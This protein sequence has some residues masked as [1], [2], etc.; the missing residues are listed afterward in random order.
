MTKTKPA[1]GTA[2]NRR[3]GST[4]ASD[5]PA[6]DVG[7][8]VRVSTEGQVQTDSPEHHELRARMYAEAKGWN[9]ARVYTLDAVSGKSVMGR[10]QTEQMLDDIRQ[11]RISGLIF[12]KLARLARNTKELLEFSEFFQGQNA[13]LISLHESIDTSI[14]AGRFFYT[15]IAGMAQWER[16]EIAER[17]AASVPIRA[18]LGKST[19]GA[20]PYGY[21]WRDGRMEPDP[22]HAPVRRLAYELFA[23]HRRLQTVARLLNEAGH[24]TRKGGEFSDTTVRRIIEDTTAKGVRRANYTKSTGD[25]KHWV[26][27]PESDWV[28]IP[29]EPIVSEELWDECNHFLD[30]RKRGRKPTRK[31]RHLFGGLVW[32]HCGEKMYVLSN[33]PK[34]TCRTCRNKVPA[35]DLEMVFAEQLKGFFLSKE[36]IAEYLAQGD[37]AQRENEDLLQTMETEK[38]KL[39]VESDKL[40]RL[41]LDDCLTPEAF[42]RRN[43][44]LEER[45]QQ[46]GE[47]LPRLQGEIDFQRI[48]NLASEEVVTEA[49]DLYSHWHDL[50]PEER[51]SIIENLVQRIKV[52]KTAIDFDDK[53]STN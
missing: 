19:G 2:G 41:Y 52:G 45:L 28:L 44:P 32:C 35:D 13:D 11:G 50:S 53:R 39:L 17:V 16:E 51:R 27:K 8:W 5:A 31:R 20:P 14:P 43:T 9:V 23:K 34:Y 40:Y 37:Q 47:E 38:K 24:R 36:Q 30:E 49:Q 26:I 46:L 4:F 3:A 7:I 42:G 18:K 25:G 15:L 33:S 1:P 12:S 22:Q 10:S 6:K 48:N 29:V 21:R